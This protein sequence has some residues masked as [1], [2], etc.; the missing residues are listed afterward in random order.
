MIKEFKNGWLDLSEIPKSKS[1]KTCHWK[2]S[3]GKH[4]KFKYDTAYGKF[5]I[6]DYDEKNKEL[7]LRDTKYLSEFK[8]QRD[9]FQMGWFKKQI[10]NYF[11]HEFK[12]KIGTNIVSNNRDL[13]IID[14]ELEYKS[15]YDNRTKKTYQISYEKYKYKCN[16]C[17]N[18][19]WIEYRHLI[20]SVGCN[21]CANRKIVQGINDIPTTDPWM[22]PYFQGGEKEAKL[23]TSGSNKRIYPMCP[24]CGR[25][26]NKKVAI[27]DIRNNKSIG[28]VCSD[29]RSYPNKFSY[30]FLNQLPITNWQPEYQ[31]DWAK[32][33]RY[34]NYFEYGDKKY[35]LE[36]DGAFH[37]KNNTLNGVTA[38]GSKIIDKYKDDLAKEHNIE[39]IRI[40]CLRSDL[41]YI[42]NNILNSSLFFVFD[43]SNINWDKCDE[44]ATKNIVKELCKYWENYN[45]PSYAELKKVFHIK[46]DTTIN[47]YLK[48]GTKFGWCNYK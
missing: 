4:V 21:V 6:L 22:I 32:P 9:N 24:D 33:Y 19:D 40:N 26:K 48:K 34:D 38:E 2:K 35:I 37:Y 25:I 43:L 1:G 47:S 3:I 13:I 27:Q 30:V 12:Y 42:K 15:C 28:C 41:S 36:M 39:V 31:P 14:R 10:S 7:L 16:K 46:S 20:T 18:E 17:G 5:I 23:Y 29:K 44:Y 45:H 11:E 8:I